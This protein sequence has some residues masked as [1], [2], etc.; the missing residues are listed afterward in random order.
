MILLNTEGDPLNALGFGAYGNEMVRPEHIT[1]HASN[2][3]DQGEQLQH[4]FM[5]QATRRIVP[6]LPIHIANLFNRSAEGNVPV[7]L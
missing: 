4:S 2:I 6:T 7:K 3:Q 5:Q 1:S